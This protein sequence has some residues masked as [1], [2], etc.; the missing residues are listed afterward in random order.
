MGSA[1]PSVVRSALAASADAGHVLHDPRPTETPEVSGLSRRWMQRAD[2]VVPQRIDDDL[3]CCL[4]AV[5]QQMF[6]PRRVATGLCEDEFARGKGV[7]GE[8]CP[9]DDGEADAGQGP[10]D[11]VHSR[12]PGDHRRDEVQLL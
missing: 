4:A 10:A 9:C 11:Q 6:R 3:I 1:K 12:A 8:Q 2:V 7:I 5:R